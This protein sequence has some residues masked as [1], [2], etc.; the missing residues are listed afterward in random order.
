MY[1]L[2]DLHALPTASL[3][4]N[5]ILQ[6]GWKTPQES[7]TRS[8]NM[9]TH[10]HHIL[11]LPFLAVP[12]LIR[13]CTPIL[14]IMFLFSHTL[15]LPSATATISSA[16]RRAKPGACPT[17]I[18][19]RLLAASMTQL[20]AVRRRLRRCIGTGI[21]RARPPPAAPFCD[22]IR[23]S[24]ATLSIASSMYRAGLSGRCVGGGEP[25]SSGRLGL[26]RG[27]GRVR[28]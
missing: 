25:G 28:R 11:L 1:W 20:M 18:S 16:S 19:G 3:P 9:T 12:T 7:K 15:L 10:R 4:T 8:T 6:N 13:I 22:R 27:G 23:I 17:P 24:G 5:S 14:C 2:T 21:S 26:I